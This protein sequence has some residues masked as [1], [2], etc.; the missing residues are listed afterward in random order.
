MKTIAQQLNIKVFP[1]RIDDKDGNIIYYEDSEGYWCKR[2]YKDGKE[3]YF[4][5]SDGYWCKKEY[6][7]GKEIYYEN[8]KGVIRDNRQKEMTIGELEKL[9]GI[10]NL[11]IVK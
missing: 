2:E 3:V 8:S 5:D 10:K 1:F 4:E 9:T 11:K 7:D 6:K